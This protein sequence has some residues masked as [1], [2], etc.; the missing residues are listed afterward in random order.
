MLAPRLAPVTAA[1]GRWCRRRGG[2]VAVGQCGPGSL[3]RLALVPCPEAAAPLAEGEV[4]VAVRA[5]GMNFRDV[6]NALGMLP[7][8]G[9]VGVEGAGV[10]V[11]T[12]PGVAGWLSG[13]G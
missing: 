12:G 5:A 4:R 3:D 7:D 13:T 11:E 8:A 6:L 9:P 1:T 10:V 2:V